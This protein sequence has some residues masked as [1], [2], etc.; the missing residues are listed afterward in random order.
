MLN[1][2][3][4]KNYCT[5]SPKFLQLVKVTLQSLLEAARQ[6]FSKAEKLI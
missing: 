6:I 4:K 3:Y 2:F 5:P 1:G